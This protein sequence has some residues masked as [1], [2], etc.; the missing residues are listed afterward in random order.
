MEKV[1]SLI[2]KHDPLAYKSSA[3][4]AIE[5]RSISPLKPQWAEVVKA[6]AQDKRHD[7]APET[8]LLWREKLKH[9]SDEV[10]CRSLMTG[11]WQYFPSVDDVLEQ[12]EIVIE[13]MATEKSDDY[14][15][16][17][18]AENAKAER[19]GRLMTDADWDE[20][21]ATYERI[22]A[23]PVEFKKSEQHRKA[24]EDH[25]LRAAGAGREA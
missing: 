2:K 22:M 5:T 15:A 7:L 13:Q 1:S 17:W 12:S 19:E 6:V 10:I 24:F 18:K 8:I 20:L 21:R 16:N 4:Q 9:L 23:R 11:K 3:T 25:K 14:W